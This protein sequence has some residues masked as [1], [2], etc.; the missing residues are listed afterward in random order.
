MGG[1]GEPRFSLSREPDGFGF[2]YGTMVK[3][4][5]SVSVNVL[6]PAGEWRG[7]MRLENYAPDAKA[8]IVFMDGEEVARVARREDLGL[9]TGQMSGAQRPRGLAGRLLRLLGRSL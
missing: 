9:A 8:W 1:G 3:D 2:Y 6:P 7:Q 4:G 5:Q